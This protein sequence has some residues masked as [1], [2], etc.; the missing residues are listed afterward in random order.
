M[1]DP[2]NMTCDPLLTYAFLLARQAI[3]AFTLLRDGR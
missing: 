1:I 3:V 2:M